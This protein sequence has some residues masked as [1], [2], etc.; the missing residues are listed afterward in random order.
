MAQFCASNA[1]EVGS[2]PGQ[3]S[4]N[5]HDSQLGWKF[6]FKKRVFKRGRRR[7]KSVRAMQ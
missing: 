1:G 5:P 2:V 7:K 6:F 4:N 3:G